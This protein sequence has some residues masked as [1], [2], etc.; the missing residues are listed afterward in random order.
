MRGNAEHSTGRKVLECERMILER[1]VAVGQRKVAQVA[2]LGHQ[3]E[4]GQVEFL[5]QGH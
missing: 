2:G 4:I 1:G 3:D 5:C